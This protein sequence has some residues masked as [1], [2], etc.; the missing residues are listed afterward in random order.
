MDL[1]VYAAIASLGFTMSYYSRAKIQATYSQLE[2]DQNLVKLVITIDDQLLSIHLINKVAQ[3]ETHHGFGI[4]LTNCK[5]RLQHIY[6]GN[7]TLTCNKTDNSHFETIL[8]LPTGGLD[9]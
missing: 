8:I 7:Y 6:G 2:S 5:K 4:G 9:A 3:H 1:L